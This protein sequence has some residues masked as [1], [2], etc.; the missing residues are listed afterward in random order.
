[1]AAN[2]SAFSNPRAGGIIAMGV[3]EGDAV[4]LRLDADFQ[5][6]PYGLPHALD[7]VG[8]SGGGRLAGQ[9]RGN[10]GLDRVHDRVEQGHLVRELV[11]QRPASDPSLGR[12]R[13][14]RHLGEALR[15]E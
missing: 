14:G 10:I 9:P 2:L 3:E 11:V 8:Y 7:R 13:V 4:D 12:D 6:H 1:M 15:A 5:P